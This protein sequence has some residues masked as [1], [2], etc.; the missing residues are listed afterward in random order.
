MRSVKKTQ[1][2]SGVKER[3]SWMNSKRIVS[4]IKKYSFIYMFLCS[5]TLFTNIY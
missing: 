5:G 3:R 1:P 4:S 2:I